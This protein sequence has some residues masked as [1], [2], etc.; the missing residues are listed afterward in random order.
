MI[1]GLQNVLSTLTVN[2]LCTVGTTPSA[3]N[4]EVPPNTGMRG[5]T[6][7]IALTFV[8]SYPALNWHTHTGV[9]FANA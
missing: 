5:K 2:N 3:M 9:G 6:P 8:L 7:P 1:P 4:S